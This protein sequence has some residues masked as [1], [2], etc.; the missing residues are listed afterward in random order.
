MFH[1]DGWTNKHK[2]MLTVARSNFGTAPK[3]VP[4]RK[5]LPLHVIM[6]TDPLYTNDVWNNPKQLSMQKIMFKFTAQN[7]S[8]SPLLMCK[9]CALRHYK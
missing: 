6:E 1:A 9:V 4:T 8:L 3:K 5:V 7:P 2:K